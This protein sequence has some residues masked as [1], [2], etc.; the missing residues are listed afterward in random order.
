[1]KVIT[2]GAVAGLAAAACVSIAPAAHA[3]S[4]VTVRPGGFISALSDTRPTGHVEFLKD[5]LHVWTEGNTSTDKAAEYVGV[6]TQ[7]IP[8]TASLN[9][10]GTQPQPGSQIVFDVDSD[11]TNA[12]TWN[13]LVGEPVY[14]DDYWYPGGTT[15]ALAHGVT[16]PQTTGGSGSDCHG[17]LAEWQSAVPAAQVYAVG[18]SLGSGVK[19]DGVI[20]DLQVGDTDY[21][22]TSDPATTVVPVTGTATVKTIVRPHVT[23]LKAHFSTDA[24]GANEVQGAKLRFKVKDNG[25]VI[26]RNQMGAGQ[27]SAAKFPFAKGSGKHVVQVLKNGVVDSTTVIKTGHKK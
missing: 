5:G 1:M 23:V 27:K 18:F 6:P 25:K 4:T 12:N 17:T 21:R 19:G 13:I 26:Y 22:F 15:R 10:I 8:G 14:G 11:R 20:R 24:L 2:K 7:G 3:D 16:C 9:W